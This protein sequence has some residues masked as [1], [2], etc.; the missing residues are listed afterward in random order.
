M[1]LFAPKLEKTFSMKSIDNILTLKTDDK[2]KGEKVE[3][4]KLDIDFEY[5]DEKLERE[6]GIN[7][8]RMFYELLDQ[9]KKWKKITLKEFNAILEVKFG[10][11]IYGNR[12]YYAFFVHL[13]GKSEYSM[14][15]MFE[16][17]DTMLEGLV[18]EYLTEDDRK[19]FR[20]VEFTIEFIQDEQIALDITDA[21]LSRS[22]R[23]VE[24]YAE[25]E[26]ISASA[27]TTANAVTNTAANPEE[28]SEFTVTN[29]I[30]KL[31]GFEEGGTGR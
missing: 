14:K 19:K 29:M 23:Q 11:E 8:A 6:I 30:F 13:A 24:S 26:E 16:K 1:P 9:L 7:F 12:D 2:D 20:D 25:L 5:E 17:Q 21:K 28:E 18:A 4:N 3:K 15:A 27:N 22:Y 10:R 31:K